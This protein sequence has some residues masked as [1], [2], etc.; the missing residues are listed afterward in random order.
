MLRST[1]FRV[2]IAAGAALALTACGE[3]SDNNDDDSTPS[4]SIAIDVAPASQRTVDFELPPMEEDGAF[5]DYSTDPAQVTVVTWGSSTC[6]AFP[7][8]ISWSNP[9]TLA[10]AM[11]EDYGEAAC[12]ADLG[13]NLATIEIPANQDGNRA[14]TVVLNGNEIE[15][16]VTE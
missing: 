2:L 16:E 14:E 11:S 6:P 3:S 5:L 9:T 7:T 1:P 4:E 10:I 13:P 8:N 12:T 15:A